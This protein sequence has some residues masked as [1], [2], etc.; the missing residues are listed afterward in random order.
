MSR[1]LRSHRV[2]AL[3]IALATASTAV[4]LA[5]SACSSAPANPDGDEPAPLETKEGGTLVIGQE[6]QISCTDWIGSCA[7]S[8]WGTYAMQVQT[9]PAA[10]AYRQSGDAW[11]PAATSLMATEPTS[12]EVDGDQVIT[13]RINPEAVWSDGEPITSADFKYTAVEIRDGKEVLDR[14][15]Y[16]RITSV[17]TPDPETAVVTLKGTYPNWRDLFSGFTGVLPAHLL[18]GKDRGAE[19]KAGYDW[20]GGPWKIEEW[21]QGESVTLVPNDKYWGDQPRLDKVVFQVTSNTAAEFQAFKSGQLDAIFPTPQLDAIQALKPGIPGARSMVDEKSANVEGIW[22]NNQT[23][24]FDQSAVRKAVAHAI[25]REAI[26]ERIYGDL[27]VEAPAQTFWPSTRS[28]FAGASFDQ[29]QLDL[30]MVDQ[31]MEGDGW[32]RNSE[33]LWEKDGRQADFEIA[34]LSG[35]ARRQLV[36]EILQSQLAEAGFRVTIKNTPQLSSYI[37]EQP[38]QAAII[39]L[40]GT[41]TTDIFATD[42]SLNFMGVSD[43][44]L[45]D[46]LAK[47]SSE[48]DPQARAEGGRASDQIIAD[49]VYS[50]PLD[51]TP[52][53]LLTRDRVGGPL[54]INPIEGPFWNLNEWGLVE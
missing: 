28:E 44:D 48:T 15:G 52:S 5:A 18:E 49:Q 31:I 12:E 25:D 8:I 41:D 43:P 42:A 7:G 24:P 9:I 20:S 16:S 29:Y 30:D 19:M 38:F 40:I 2:S 17:K 3:R 34:S 45:D 47:V 46:E 14:T 50:L 32:S 37:F 6:Q 1:N 53:L 35:D 36:T 10:F 54:S 13:Y 23:F 27:G 11:Q 21:K 39:T 22:F 51:T 33:G 26:V 4:V